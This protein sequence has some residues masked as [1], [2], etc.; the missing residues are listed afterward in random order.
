MSVQKLACALVIVIDCLSS[1]TEAAPVTVIEYQPL[2]QTDI[3]TDD[4]AVIVEE[5]KEESLVSELF[6]AM[7]L[8]PLLDHHDREQQQQHVKQVNNKDSNGY[9]YSKKKINRKL[10]KQLQKKAGSYNKKSALKAKIPSYHRESP[11]Y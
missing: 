7:A 6:Y 5:K 9:S 10:F 2:E 3:M 4:Q 1:Q 8:K 11:T